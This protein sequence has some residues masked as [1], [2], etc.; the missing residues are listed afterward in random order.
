MWPSISLT[1][2]LRENEHSAHN[3]W[4]HFWLQHS[5]LIVPFTIYSS[6]YFFSYLFHHIHFCW[7]IIY[8]HWLSLHCF[9]C[10]LFSQK[11]IAMC[12][13][14]ISLIVVIQKQRTACFSIV[15]NQVDPVLVVS[16][17]GFTV[18]SFSQYCFICFFKSRFHCNIGLV[19]PLLTICLEY[20]I[21]IFNASSY[22]WTESLFLVVSSIALIS[23]SN[24]VPFL[25]HILSFLDF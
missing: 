8:N 11:N 15:A 16:K 17:Y 19:V 13:L 5:S 21:I 9:Y 10:V 20:H 7:S 14:G 25:H 4:I 23:L 24:A 1:V 2:I 18:T 3:K 6:I 12:G 22:F